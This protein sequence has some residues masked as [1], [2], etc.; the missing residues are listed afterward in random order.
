MSIRH[1]LI[2]NGNP[3][4]ALCKRILSECILSLHLQVYVKPW[5]EKINRYDNTTNSRLWLQ[6]MAC[7]QSRPANPLKHLA[8]HEMKKNATKKAEICWAAESS[9][10]LES[11]HFLL[12]KTAAIVLF[13]VYRQ[14]KEKMMQ[15]SGKYI[16]VP[17]FFRCGAGNEIKIR[18]RSKR[19][20]NVSLST[21]G[22]LS[23]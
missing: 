19:N 8:H 11:E 16:H 21:F 3:W 10:S 23:L 18:Q 7:L 13:S 17:I 5:K 4:I 14:L 9:I 22:S 1:T 12:S 6:K 20:S 15:Y 2:C